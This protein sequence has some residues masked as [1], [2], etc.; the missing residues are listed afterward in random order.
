MP[1]HRTW[2]HGIDD[3]VFDDLLERQ[4]G[5][6]AICGRVEVRLVIDHDHDCCPSGGY[7]HPN[8]GL[9]VRGLICVRCNNLLGYLESTPEETLRRALSYIAGDNPRG[10][11]P[12]QLDPLRLVGGRVA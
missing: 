3:D 5:G 10:Y 7:R 6:C 1:T 11:L 12:R 9:C 2:R 8:C 4:N